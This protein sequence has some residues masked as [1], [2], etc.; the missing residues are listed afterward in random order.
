LV[1]AQEEDEDR[2]EPEMLCLTDRRAVQLIGVQEL[3]R[4][5]TSE[6]AGAMIVAITVSSVA[7]SLGT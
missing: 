3:Q 4:T 2:R 7:A 6:P 1:S 5:S